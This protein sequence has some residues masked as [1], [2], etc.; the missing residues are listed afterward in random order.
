VSNGFQPKYEAGYSNGIARNDV[1]VVLITSDASLTEE[2]DERIERK[3]FRGSIKP[4]RSKR[5]KL[6]N[7]IAYYFSLWRFLLGEGYTVHLI[8]LPQFKKYVKVW[9]YELLFYKWLSGRVILTVHNL[10]PHGKEEHF[11]RSTL[12]RYYQTPD[13]LLVHSPKMKQALIEEYGVKEDRITVVNIGVS[14]LPE[15]SEREHR[16]AKSKF[17]YNERDDVILLLGNVSHY[18]GIDLMLQALNHQRADSRFK[19]LIAGQGGANAYSSFLK[20]QIKSSPFS[21]D[22][23]WINR[24]LTEEE[25]GL[26]LKAADVLVLPY[27]HID[28]SG[29]LLTG[30]EFGLPIVAFD[31]GIIRDFIKP[32]LGK[33]VEPLDIS[34]LMH[35][36]ETVH[37]KN[38]DRALIQA[39]AKTLCW[40][41]TVQP[42][43]K[44]Y[45]KGDKEAVQ[46][47]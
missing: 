47:A 1:P 25:V 22:I 30:L 41:K 43:L 27:R 31:V 26:A 16:Q 15:L 23:Q 36:V 14:T 44:H 10:V 4:N 24:Y 19:V 37:A 7:L 21:G 32:G 34:G 9:R 39:F 3:N 40:D 46:A 42:I 18:K 6:A 20:Q 28:Q 38:V 12:K 29:V 2:L 17:G 33:I 45:E 11:A 5:E 35:A 13:H 8:G